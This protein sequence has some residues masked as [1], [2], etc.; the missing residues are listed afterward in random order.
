MVG[1]AHCSDSEETEGWTS[2][3]EE[4]ILSEETERW[5][6]VREEYILNENTEGWTGGR[7]EFILSNRK[8]GGAIYWDCRF[9]S[10]YA[11]EANLEHVVF[12]EPVEHRSG[13][14]LSSY[15]VNY[16]EEVFWYQGGVSLYIMRLC[17]QNTFMSAPH[18]SSHHSYEMK[19]G[20]FS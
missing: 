2:G 17:F 13:N 7:E 12:T 6:G 20:S 11:D 19:W 5:T 18:R 3:R 10:W 15:F 14:I 16:P 8:V 1:L 4:Y 9:W